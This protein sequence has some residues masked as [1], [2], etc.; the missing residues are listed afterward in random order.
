MDKIAVLVFEEKE[1]TV[2]IYS[3]LHTEEAVVLASDL[4][5]EKGDTIIGAIKAL[6]GLLNAD[7][8]QYALCLVDDLTTTDEEKAERAAR[9][10]VEL[11]KLANKDETKEAPKVKVKAKEKS[12]P[13]SYKG[14]CAG[15]LIEYEG[16]GSVVLRR[17]SI[18]N[19]FM[20]VVGKPTPYKDCNG[21]ELKVGDLLIVSERAGTTREGKKWE[22]LPEL[23]YMCDDGDGP[24]VMGIY[25]AC[26]PKTGKIDGRLKIRRVKSWQEIEIGDTSGFLTVCYE[27]DG[28]G[29]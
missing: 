27:P 17:T 24:F 26:N 18:G 14:V 21:I 13:K 5:C 11:D 23:V 3:R 25:S 22:E 1:D 15:K 19:E 12:K 20:G 10:G 28:G 8:L 2:S 9:A 7:P 16:E 29:K 4:S 6:C